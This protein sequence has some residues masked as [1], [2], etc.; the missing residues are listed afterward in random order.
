MKVQN[1]NRIDISKIYNDNKPKA[2]SD[3]QKMKKAYDSVEISKEGME[4][5]R[6]VN[7]SREMS[8]VRIQKVN[9]IKS[10]IQHGVYKVSSEDLAAKIF[11]AIKEEK[12]NL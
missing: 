8:D 10:K 12:N 5:A 7:M 9:E 6:Y 3:M 1:N 11:E 2:S 4:I